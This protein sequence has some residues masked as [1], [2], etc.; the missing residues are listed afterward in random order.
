VTSSLRISLP[1]DTDN[2]C[3]MGNP[4]AHSKS[5]Q[6]HKIFAKQTG[7]NLSYQAILVEPGCFGEALSE[8]Q[9]QGGKGLNIT[10]PFKGD[11]CEAVDYLTTRAKKAA[12]VNTIWFDGNGESHGDTTDATGLVNDLLANDI[13]LQ[14]KNILI[15]GAGGA[16]RG[17]LDG[18]LE[19]GV[20][21]I[22]IANRTHSTAEELVTNYCSDERL[23]ASEFTDLKPGFF[24]IIINGTSAS[25]Y[26][27]LLPIDATLAMNTC[28]Y[29]MVYADEDTC[30]VKW[31][32]ENGARIA[33]DGLGMLVHQAAASFYIWRDVSPQTS[34]VIETIRS[35]S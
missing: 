17:V 18:L 27:E 32:R 33:L 15:L 11:A 9:R 7:Q 20:Q 25:L 12:A 22:T 8:F 10:V 28:C 34:S 13:Q 24:E 2:Y 30:F 5:P 26:G 35:K 14:D 23:S 29:D 31:A 1:A 21:S 19:Q 3:V 6:I 4:I 16:V